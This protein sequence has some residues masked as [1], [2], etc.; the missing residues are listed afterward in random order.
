MEE[1]SSELTPG[2]LKLAHAKVLGVCFSVSGLVMTPKEHF[3][4]Y[5]GFMRQSVLYKMLLN[6]LIASKRLIVLKRRRKLRPG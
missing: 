2:T 3:T 4:A 1:L 6:L 5:H